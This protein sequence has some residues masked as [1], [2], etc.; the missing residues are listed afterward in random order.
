MKSFIGLDKK[1]ENSY[2][3]TYLEEKMCL[4]YELMLNKSLLQELRVLAGQVV[5][6]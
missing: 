4:K 3:H 1:D 5:R 6:W 2:Y